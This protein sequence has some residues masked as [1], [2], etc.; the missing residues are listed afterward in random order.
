MGSLLVAALLEAEDKQTRRV[1]RLNEGQSPATTH[2]EGWDIFIQEF[3][4]FNRQSTFICCTQVFKEN[5]YST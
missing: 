2:M 3:L 1:K 4:P 5:K